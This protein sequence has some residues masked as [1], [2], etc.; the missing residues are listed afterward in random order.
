MN[1][2]SATRQAQFLAL[3][4]SDVQ[5]RILSAKTATVY[6]RIAA[7][8]F[9]GS[10]TDAAIRSYSYLLQIEAVLAYLRGYDLIAEQ[11]T[12]G[13]HLTRRKQRLRHA[14]KERKAEREQPDYLS[15]QLWTRAEID[16]VHACLPKTP[17]GEEIWR[18]ME[19]AI[20]TGMRKFEILKMQPEHIFIHDL[21]V[22]ITVIGK[23]RKRRYVYAPRIPVL[24]N[25]TP[26]T[27]TDGYLT[28]T[29]RRATTRA[30][31]PHRTFHGLRH[32]Y[33]SENVQDG[34]DVLDMQEQLGHS[35]LKT[36]M[37]Y[38]HKHHECPHSLLTR[39]QKRGLLPEKHA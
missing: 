5:S 1:T 32:T 28:T 10:L 27:I 12:F 18:A 7:K 9:D 29:F 39:W 33:S 15:E 25:F 19:I 30:G 6:A 3:I 36:T 13:L 4:Q 31:L 21:S 34:V 17:E 20:E 38:L 23:R 24:L 22:R 8:L 26:F 35:S 11:E 2:D 14:A 37:I 16:A